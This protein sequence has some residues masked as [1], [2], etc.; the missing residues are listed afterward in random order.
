[1]IHTRWSMSY[2]RGPLT[3]QQVQILMAEQRQHMLTSQPAQVAAAGYVRAGGAVSGG[4]TQPTYSAYNAMPMS[5]VAPP[6]S[7]P[8][9][10]SSLPELGEIPTQTAPLMPPEP[11][12]TSMTQPVA[13]NT[14]S[15]TQ[16]PIPGY[17]TRQPPLPAA[18]PQYFLPAAISSQQAI[19]GWEQ[20]TNFSAQ[21]FGG[22]LLAYKPVLLAQATVRYQARKANVYSAR[23]F[24][25]H[26]PDV[27]RAGI[28]HWEQYQAQ[29]VDT[30]AVS[31]EPFGEA[32]FGDIPTGLTD[33][34]RVA[35]LRREYG[36]MLY[37][38]ALL[39]LPYNAELDI[40]ANPDGDFSEFHARVMQVARERRDAEVDALTQKYEKLL[41]RHD[42]DMRKAAQ[43]LES[44]KHQLDQE[45]RIELFTTG[46]A[47]ASL[48]K[49]RT[50][51]TLSRMARASLF[52]K[53][54]RGDVEL[55]RQNLSEL[56]EKIVE[57]EEQFE[58]ELKIVN[59]RWARV[60]QQQ[61]EFVIQPY[62][63]DI[64]I[65]MFGIGW[66]PFYYANINGQSLML[67]AY[68]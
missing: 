5:P 41:D 50:A 54:S 18:T 57:L 4:V 25:Y 22:A 64:M 19:Q 32:A 63:K 30:K 29:P 9:M 23:A 39:R 12:Q 8:E 47:V 21:S 31:G 14:Q 24:A 46:E 35:G 17:S 68:T 16:S 42:E 45:K 60:A 67:P 44:E 20:R 56:D 49:G 37:N 36:D 27:E 66:I 53:R 51:F 10:P 48:L 3:R 33:A 7:L 15:T 40:Y 6:P 43:K 34:K 38:T 62:K 58:R 11:Y 2:L 59:D 61:S 28:I 13:R 65:D 55:H 1:M 26:V 52:R